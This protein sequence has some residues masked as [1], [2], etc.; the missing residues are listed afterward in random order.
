MSN[1][2]S[3]PGWGLDESPF[4]EGELSVQ[5]RV[6][7]REKMAVTGR[8]VMREYLTGQHREFFG[9]LPYIFVGSVDAH[10]QP[11][12]SILLGQPGFLDA[13]DA[14][15]VAVQARPLHGDPLG[16]NLRLGA[17]I[18]MLGVQLHTRRRNRFFGAISAVGHGTFTVAVRQTLGICPQYIQG[19]EPAFHRDPM[20]EVAT[21]VHR[22]A[23]LD[24]RARDIIGNADTYFVASSN[25][26]EGAGAARGADVSHRG[27][28]PGFVRIDDD[29]TLTAPD[30]VGNFIFNTLGN[31]QLDDRAGL[32]FIDFERG[33]VLYLAA[34]AEI[35]WDGPEV[36]AF[37]GAQRLVR[38]RIEQVVHVEASLPAHFSPPEHS[39]LLARTGSWRDVEQ[40]LEA[41]RMRNAWRPL[42]IER[43]VDEAAQIR[44]YH[45]AP[46]DG[47]GLAT[48]TPGQFLPI[49]V[50]PEGWREPANRTYTLS[51]APGGATYRITVKREG[52]GGVSDWLHDRAAVGTLIEAKAPRGAF[53]FE[54]DPRSPVVLISAGVGITPMIAMVD[55]LL[56]NQGRTLHHAPIWFV[57]GAR[58]DHA[59][60][61]F[62]ND[63]QARHGNFH[64]HVRYS[65]PR[66]EDTL[67]VTHD[68]EGQIDI[69]LLKSI[70][71]FDSYQFY[72]CGPA[73]FMQSLY[74][75]LTGL[76]VPDASIHFERFGPA[77]VA[78]RKTQA[79]APADDDAE[80]SIVVT[81]A[82]S[83]KT[84]RWRPSCGSLLELAEA[85]GV[86]ALSSCRVGMCGACSAGIV[87]GSVD[88][89]APPEHEIAPGTALLCCATPHPG[90]H[91]HDSLDREGVS[92]DL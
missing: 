21:P 88:Y 86:P 33:D 78:R 6:G 84:A 8:Q 18:A 65:R 91:L 41:E 50:Q 27:G 90:P 10:G 9:L 47:L 45:L 39:P 49:R 38:Y 87:S 57:H 23:R 46:A 52:A 69:A 81:F 63:K 51:S 1:T 28:Q 59:F 60:R 53:A 44:S 89:A 82:K 61:A 5:A 67:G 13:P 26:R 35:V 17:E 85:A 68:S 54:A 24:A 77:S 11:W 19:R 34:R 92:L 80:E 25:L 58:R 66:P 14:H 36:R 79:P 2:P 72:L 16:A 22:H 48:Y 30:F 74:D 56:V 4:H 75:G 12:A 73:A 70:L 40:T 15:T 76:G 42:R 7:V 71:P 20:H 83:G 62:L 31:W 64:A 43:I 37:A 32:L 55:S 29:A 3:S